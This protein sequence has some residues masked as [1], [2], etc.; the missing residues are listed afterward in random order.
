MAGSSAARPAT[1]LTVLVSGLMPFDATMAEIEPV[2]AFDAPTLTEL[3]GRNWITN[4]GNIFNQRYSTL[5]QI[6]RENITD[7]KAVWRVS[8]NGSGMEP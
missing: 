3:P 8:L 4:G 6:N 2:P 7:V 5:D 1:V